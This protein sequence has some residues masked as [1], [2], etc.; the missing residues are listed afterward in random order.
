MRVRTTYILLART[1][2]TRL[3]SYSRRSQVIRGVR[4]CHCN[5][6]NILLYFSSYHPGFRPDPP[7]CLHRRFVINRFHRLAGESHPYTL[8]QSCPAH[9]CDIFRPSFSPP[10]GRAHHLA[11]YTCSP[12]PNAHHFFGPFQVTLQWGVAMWSTHVPPVCIFP[13]ARHVMHSLHENFNGVNS[14]Y[15]TPSKPPSR[16]SRHCLGRGR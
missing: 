1:L 8:F 6:F 14:V 13:K 4:S 10:V 3:D 15:V 12:R 7:F 2:G 5:F 9:K 11:P 16:V